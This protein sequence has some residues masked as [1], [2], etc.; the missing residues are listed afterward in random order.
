[1]CIHMSM[2]VYVDIQ[3][4]ELAQTLKMVMGDDCV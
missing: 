1:M 4:T 3:A 2:Y